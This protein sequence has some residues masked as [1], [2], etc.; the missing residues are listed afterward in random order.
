VR[1]RCFV[2][3]CIYCNTFHSI[4]GT[5]QTGQSITRN[6]LNAI[7]RVLFNAICWLLLSYT[8]CLLTQ[9]PVSQPF[10]RLF[11]LTCRQRGCIPDGH[12]L[13]NAAVSPRPYKSHCRTSHRAGNVVV[14][15]PL[16]RVRPLVSPA[17]FPLPEVFPDFL[18]FPPALLFADL[19]GSAS[20]ISSVAAASEAPDAP[21]TRLSSLPALAFASFDSASAFA[22]SLAT[23]AC[24]QWQQV[25]VRFCNSS[26]FGL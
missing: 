2:G 7:A 4:K 20:V 24:F 11:S 3:L 23:C 17:P 6:D 1:L 10:S 13:S 14:L 18:P 21:S 22:L 15:D 5:I 12:Q 25:P 19:T 8:S 9:Y 16:R 26:R